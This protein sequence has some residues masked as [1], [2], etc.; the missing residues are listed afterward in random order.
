MDIVILG[1]AIAKN[2]SKN[3]A[4]TFFYE[5]APQQIINNQAIIQERERFLILEFKK[6]VL[7]IPSLFL[8]GISVLCLHPVAQQTLCGTYLLPNYWCC[9]RSECVC[10]VALQPRRAD[11]NSFVPHNCHVVPLERG[12]SR[13]LLLSPVAAA[14]VLLPVHIPSLYA[15][16]R[17]F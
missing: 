6:E 13:V 2:P 1:A 14:A 7:K 8:G 15:R 17:L 16:R 12:E 10:I 3:F 4:T 9:V 11:G 5:L